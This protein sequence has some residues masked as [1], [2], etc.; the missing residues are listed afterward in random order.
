MKV[1]ATPVKKIQGVSKG[2]DKFF[3]EDSAEIHSHIG[4]ILREQYTN[5]AWAV[6]REYIQNAIDASIGVD[7]KI[8]VVLPSSN[9]QVFEVRDYG[10]G[11]QA[12]DFHRFMLGYGSTD[13]LGCSDQIGGF[14]I[15]SKCGLA[16]TD[17]YTYE[18]VFVDKD[19]G[20]T[21]KIV[22]MCFIDENLEPSSSVLADV[23]VDPVE[24]PTGLLV[25]IPVKSDDIRRFHL[26]VGGLAI[27]DKTYSRLNIVSVNSGIVVSMD[28]DIRKMVPTED[29]KL[30]KT[31]VNVGGHEVCVYVTTSNVN[32][33]GDGIVSGIVVILNGIP[34]KVPRDSL[35]SALPNRVFYDSH[36]TYYSAATVIEVD[37]NTELSPTPSREG[38]KMTGI[39]ANFI[40]NCLNEHAAASAKAYVKDTDTVI[41]SLGCCSQDCRRLIFLGNRNLLKIGNTDVNSGSVFNIVSKEMDISGAE[42]IPRIID[43]DTFDIRQ[44]IPRDM[45]AVGI[46]RNNTNPDILNS[47]TIRNIISRGINVYSLSYTVNRQAITSLVFKDI[48]DRVIKSSN[49]WLSRKYPKNSKERFA[50]LSGTESKRLINILI[51]EGLKDFLKGA[52][53]NRYYGT[54]RLLIM[55]PVKFDTVLGEIVPEDY[56]YKDISKWFNDESAEKLS[57]VKINRAWPEPVKR[58]YSRRKSG[59][60]STRVVKGQKTRLA[61]VHGSLF[62]YEIPYTHRLVMKAS[63]E[64]GNG[65]ARNSS[66]LS[67]K[68]YTSSHE[69]IPTLCFGGD[70]EKRITY[71]ELVYFIEHGEYPTDVTKKY[72]ED[73]CSY[74]TDKVVNMSPAPYYDRVLFADEDYHTQS[75]MKLLY[76]KVEEHY[77]KSSPMVKNWFKARTVSRNFTMRFAGGSLD[78]LLSKIYNKDKVNIRNRKFEELLYYLSQPSDIMCNDNLRGSRY[79]KNLTDTDMFIGVLLGLH[80]MHYSIEDLFVDADS[81]KLSARSTRL[82]SNKYSGH[83]LISDIIDELVMSGHPLFDLLLK[84]TVYV[85]VDLPI[86]EAIIN[87]LSSFVD[88]TF[89]TEELINNAISAK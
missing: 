73:N 60:S 67:L 86:S 8:D 77:N 19:T 69:T 87:K 81:A 14:G 28:E 38:I 15:G 63:K 1:V 71:P 51:G 26:L 68:S 48:P 2:E 32:I 50:N 58:T 41:K 74:D 56:K 76:N 11:M 27:S 55:Q 45:W 9:N 61:R 57:S 46:Y 66:L 3:I 24:N 29:D 20:K 44:N 64:V 43:I 52:D 75:F 18:N 47:S 21:R 78:A 34:Y 70:T 7:R 54:H 10:P 62:G 13:K 85:G 49:K 23:Y 82:I 31:I 4:S 36:N 12:D 42:Y 39:A 40:A 17:T 35:T 22:R 37:G 88:D 25:K 6:V 89:F 83:K 53:V 33:G 79:A 59:G 30:M 80:S 84:C 5:P 16:Y 72:I 65:E